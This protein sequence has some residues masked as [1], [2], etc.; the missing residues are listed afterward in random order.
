MVTEPGKRGLEPRALDRAR[1]PDARLGAALATLDVDRDEELGVADDALGRERD[2]G[3]A[4]HDGA[5]AARLAPPA[6][7]VGKPGEHARRGQEHVPS[8]GA[9]ATAA[10]GARR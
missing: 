1:E 2:A 7:P 6:D 8:D 9:V 5:R 4:D 3:A 10:R